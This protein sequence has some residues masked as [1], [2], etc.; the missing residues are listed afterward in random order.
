MLCVSYRSL[1]GVTRSLEIP[2]LR[3]PNSIED[4]GDSYGK[5]FFISLDAR[6][7]FHQIRVRECDQEK[8]AI[9]TLEGNKKYYFLELNNAPALYT[10][11][12]KIFHDKWYIL[13]N[14]TKDVVSPDISDSK[15]FYDSKKIID[16]TLI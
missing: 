14:S 3:C 9:F 7:G 10:S 1:N 15:I 11:M 4:F 2:I 5:L 8:V 16:D 13:F 12:M 6:Y